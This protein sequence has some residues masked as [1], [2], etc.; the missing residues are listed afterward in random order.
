[1]NEALS[2]TKSITQEQRQRMEQR[3]LALHRCYASLTY[4]Q[5]LQCIGAFKARRQKLEL[6]MG[7]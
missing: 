4:A 3:W 2:T 7:W 1:M 6:A 5:Q